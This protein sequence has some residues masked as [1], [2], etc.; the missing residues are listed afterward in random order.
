M[1]GLGKAITVALRILVAVD[2]AVSTNADLQEAWAMYKDVVMEWSEQRRTVS[3]A[4]MCYA[5][6]NFPCNSDERL[7]SY[8]LGEHFRQ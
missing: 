4:S 1:F 2:T 7:W 6:L 5:H 8:Y 3:N